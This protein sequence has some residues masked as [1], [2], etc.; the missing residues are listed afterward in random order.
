LPDF[1]SPSITSLHKGHQCVWILFAHRNSVRIV[2][3]S[4]ERV[5]LVFRAT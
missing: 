2:Y 3:P 4:Y 1:S 5:K